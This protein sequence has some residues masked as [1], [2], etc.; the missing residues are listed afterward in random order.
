MVINNLNLILKMN[1]KKRRD[2]AVTGGPRSKT[3]SVKETER[4]IF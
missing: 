4:N 3:V 2:Q 1:Y